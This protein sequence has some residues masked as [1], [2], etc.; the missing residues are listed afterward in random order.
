MMR[1]GP[2]AFAV[3]LSM[4]PIPAIASQRQ[5]T[6]VA[7]LEEESIP[8][9]DLVAPSPVVAPSPDA[10]TNPN[11][12]E[13]IAAPAGEPTTAESQA[14][15]PN[16]SPGT[17]PPAAAPTDVAPAIDV[18]S[19]A[20]TPQISDSSLA[21]LID[22][23]PT[24]ARAASLRIT[25]QQRVELEQ[26]HTD[27]A[28]RE[29]AHAISIDPSNSYAYFYLGRA[30]VTRKDYAQ[31]QTFFKRAEIGLASDSAWLGEIYA[32][33]GLSLEE[34]GKSAEAAAAY[35]KALAAAPG[36]LT[37][38]VGVTRLSG[39]V[40]ADANPAPAPDLDQPAP[41]EP[42]AAPPPEEAPAAPPPPASPPA[43]AD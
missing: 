14:P 4:L 21:P 38:R 29:L 7:R 15:I 3:F 2:F 30:Y 10:D 39:S 33:E 23:A 18:G 36:N 11:S 35:Q 17:Q 32:F 5:P 34:S 24:P 25:E 13:W 22:A 12:G 6:L 26:G 19:I 42:S 40:P 43:P 1:L 27:G 9:Q 16:P 8:A 41:A 31:A 20:T 28:I 37:A